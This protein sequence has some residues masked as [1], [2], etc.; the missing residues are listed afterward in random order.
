MIVEQYPGNSAAFR[1][2][3]ANTR[4]QQVNA[5]KFRLFK[6]PRSRLFARSIQIRLRLS[7][8]ARRSSSS[9]PI[10]ERERETNDADS[11]SLTS[12]IAFGDVN[13]ND[14]QAR[15]H[16]GMARN[17]TPCHAVPRDRTSQQ[18]NISWRE[19]WIPPRC[20]TES[21]DS[22]ALAVH[23]RVRVRALSLSSLCI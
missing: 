18:A 12:R 9:R 1:S 14:V 5:D 8:S 11:K 7:F 4:R 19:Q 22:E 21:P 2:D 10:Q 15:M 6:K 3:R 20:R 23:T 13:N 17:A 16:P